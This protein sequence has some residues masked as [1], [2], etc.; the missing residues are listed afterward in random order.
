MLRLMNAVREIVLP[1]A[2]APGPQRA[3][4]RLDLRFR[5]DQSGRTRIQNFYQ[6][7]CLRARLP[8]PVDAAWCEAVVMNVS[9]GIAGGDA[10]TSLITLDEGASAIVAAQA[11]ERVYRALD[12]QSARLTQEI[13]LGAGAA[14]DF[15]PQETI[16]FD[17][18]ALDRR[19]RAELGAGARYL[20]V[21]SLVFGRQA[22]GEALL[23]GALRDRIEIFREGKL[24]LCDLVRLAGDLA[25]LL[26]RP[27][28]AAGA[29]AMATLIYAAPD[30]SARLPPLRA[31]LELGPCEAGASL[32][33]SV[34]VARILAPD[35]ASLRVSVLAA[36]A[37]CRDGRALPRVWQG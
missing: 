33:D 31:A 8:R 10:L 14:L 18:F 22:M 30:A 36:L 6:A 34:L 35:S 16:L 13:T 9:G 12:G 2:G 37:I 15:L 27:A 5:R 3:L 11:A 20:S 23:S 32:V 7:G 1:V 25:A 26:A 29:R 21:E 24:V 17:G 19:L 28:V 4:G